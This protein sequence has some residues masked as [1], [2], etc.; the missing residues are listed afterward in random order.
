MYWRPTYSSTECDS[1]AGAATVP[2]N[3]TATDEFLA[4]LATVSVPLK[5]PEV[6]DSNVKS[7]V[8]LCAL[9]NCTG[10]L[11]PVMLNPVPLKETFETVTATFPLF[12][13]VKFCDAVLPAL[14]VPKL[15][16]AGPTE[17]DRSSLAASPVTGREA[18]TDATLVMIDTVPL[19]A[20][21]LFGVTST[22]SVLLVPGA[23][24][25]EPEKPLTLTPLPLATTP[26]TVSE[27]F[28]LFNSLI[29]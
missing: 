28:P 24:S 11:H 5:F 6:F 2:D 29:V 4:S 10:V 3:G 15:T 17:R 13:S 23:N 18:L 22:V 27:A 25:V 12:V 7:S 21:L 26:T 20:P 19:K 14:T 16:L 8:T 9:A 1:T